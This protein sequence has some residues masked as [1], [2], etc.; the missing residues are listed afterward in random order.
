MD[1]QVHPAQEL[2][3]AT[4]V[5]G[6]A[7]DLLQHVHVT[8]QIGRLEKAEDI[9]RGLQRICT[10]SSAELRHAHVVYLE[11]CYREVAMYGTG[12]QGETALQRMQKWFEAQIYK[13]DVPLHA[14]MLVTM[15]RAA[16]RAL[17]GTQRSR[18]VL[19][20]ISMAETLEEDE[21][22]EVLESEDY[23]DGEFATLNHISSGTAEIAGDSNETEQFTQHRQSEVPST[24]DLPEVLSTKQRGL[25]LYDVKR[26]L[27][28]QES[29]PSDAT[30]AQMYEYAYK[31]QERIEEASV[32][33]ATDRWRRD[34]E[35]LR[36]RGIHTSMQHRSVGALM[37]QWHQA[38][39]PALKAEAIECKKLLEKPGM[40]LEDDRYY[41]AAYLDLLPLENIAATTILQIMLAM[42]TGKIRRIDKYEVEGKVALL[43]T[44]LAKALEAEHKVS[45]STSAKSKH[46]ARKSRGSHHGAERS[47]STTRP[48]SKSALERQ[49]ML[50]KLEW[51]LDATIKLGSFL[52]AKLMELA[53]MPVTRRDPRTGE[54][55][56]QMQPVF[57]HRTKFDGGKRVG[58]ITPNIALIDLLASE[59]LGS[60]LAKRMPM[61]VEPK[62]WKSWTEGGYL[63]YPNPILRLSVGDR[64]GKEYFLA[65]HK[66][67]DIDQV[68]AGLNALGEVPWKIH[69]GVFKV[70]LEAWNDGQ[71]IANFAPLHPEVRI[72]Q[73]PDTAD[74][75]AHAS[76]EAD[77]KDLEDK[78]AGLHSKRCFQNLQ[79][80][81]ARTMINDT[82]Y[83][84]HNLDFR[85]R[86][87][88]IPPYLNHMGADNVRGLL[89][90][91][92]GKMLGQNGL[93]WLKI[94]LATIAG[95]DKAS[96]SERL[97]FT[98]SHLD[99]IYDSVR[100]PLTGRRWWLKAEDSWQTLAACFELTEALDSEDPT[101][102]VS[103]LPIQQ[104]GTC[105]G[106]QHYAALGG[107]E[108]GAAQVNLMPGDRPADVY[109]AVAEAVKEKVRIDAAAGNPVAQRLDGKLT[110]KC[111]KQPVMTNVYG[112]TWYG[113]KS[114]VRRQLEVIF[115]EAQR[116]D[117]VNLSNMSHYVATKI[118]ES[119][120]EMFTGAQAIQNWLGLCADRISTCLSPQ[121]V[122]ELSAP[123]RIESKQ[124]RPKKLNDVVKS[125]RIRE[126]FVASKPGDAGPK[127]A[128]LLF[129]ST[130]V[131]T[132]PLRLPVV[133]PYR[134]ENKRRIDTR[135]QEIQLRDPQLWH[136]V[137]RKK[138]LQ[139]FPPNF[140]HSLDAT[141]MLLSALKSKE[142]GLM[143]ASV[144]DS[145][146][147][148]ACDVDELSWVL[149]D[150]FIE[151]H[152]DN[153][154][155]RLREEFETR[156]KGYLQ[157]AHVFASSPAGKRISQWRKEHKSMKSHEELAMEAE[158]L[159]LLTS[160]DPDEQAKGEAMATPGSLLVDAGEASLAVPDELGDL[161]L[162]TIPLEV[163]Q[164]V[165]D[166]GSEEEGQPTAGPLGENLEPSVNHSAETPK[167]P[168]E[169]SSRAPPKPYLKK[170][171]VWTPLTFPP[172]PPRGS[173]DVQKIRDSPYFFS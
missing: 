14:N 23:D 27:E 132:T 65:A 114:Q 138:Q 82:L 169:R 78:R 119:L 100:N 46:S 4:G 44:S 89:V 166:V 96:I 52:L 17:E 141:H 48:L 15:I 36:K 34:D 6:S 85:G 171:N 75:V 77:V 159:R 113:A 95:H 86:A 69:R 91:A 31:R 136:P 38:L 129:K 53:R 28:G 26:T 173:F 70:Q 41:Y 68:Y 50:A 79:M 10:S 3:I 16:I 49:A 24:D 133:Q 80:E 18:T 45:L 39:L 134:E 154:I 161:G 67:G 76:W 158:R 144:H 109:T 103:H 168:A 87:Y 140:I 104:D 127:L 47:A 88:P 148:H 110:R 59:P 19:R 9:I 137:S 146:W 102:Y 112:V 167:P 122:A 94:H 164:T 61:V 40:H 105:N 153:I 151:M 32:H 99:D 37:W 21:R 106:L 63:H 56:T 156:Y 35:D 7:L 97:E 125:S 165:D 162:G 139:A 42:N 143:F 157:H 74:Y 93:R 170:L 33:V 2:Q 55:N 20:Y 43:A 130:V 118:F 29:R 1:Q 25:G 121:Q 126:N 149:R 117:A 84:P 150:A 8:V 123:S 72:P 172:I 142:R 101:K 120:G 152:Q 60:L 64:S 116:A 160:E 147:T 30:P 73:E 58:I 135:L 51:P 111:V 22:L 5:Q 11:G 108:A 66:K 12:M 163:E 83:F 115:P 62:P 54:N 92:K 81:I 107:D 155:G 124:P 57:Q 131:W 145:F 98:M 71:A 13:A 90:F 128:K